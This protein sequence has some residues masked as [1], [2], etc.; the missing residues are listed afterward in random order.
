M[1]TDLGGGGRGMGTE[2]GW[3]ANEVAGR[4]REGWTLT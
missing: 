2:E 1:D 4:D 3:R